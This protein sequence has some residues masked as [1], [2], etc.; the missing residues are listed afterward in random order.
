MFFIFVGAVV[1]FCVCVRSCSV[2]K[3][4]AVEMGSAEHFGH[5]GDHGFICE[6]RVIVH[7]G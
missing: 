1:P 6:R 7:T 4:G 3:V 5:V 2:C